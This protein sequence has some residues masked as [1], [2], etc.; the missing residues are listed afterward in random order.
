[1]SFDHP[2]DNILASAVSAN[3][4]AQHVEGLANARCV[5]KEE[6]EYAL[7]L[8]GRRFLQPLFRCLLHVAIVLESTAI[9]DVRVRIRR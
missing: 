1:M 8:V 6:L 9:V 5:S 2:D 7:S 4:L 3:G